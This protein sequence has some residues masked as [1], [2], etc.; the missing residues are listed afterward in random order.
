MEVRYFLRIQGVVQGVGFRPFVYNLARRFNLRGFVLNDSLGVIIEVEGKKHTVELFLKKLKKEAPPSSSIERIEK[1][2]IPL[3]KDSGFKIEESKKQEEKFVFIP[4]DLS[5]CDDCL[6][7][8]FNKDD[9]RYFY[10]FINCTKCGPRYTIIKDVPY[11]RAN[12]TMDKFKMCKDCFAEYSDA[13]SRRFH[14]QPNAC[15]LC[16][17]SID[18]VSSCKKLKRKVQK[19]NRTKTQEIIEKTA[20]ALYEGKIVAIKG[21]GGYHIACDARNINTVRLLRE[22]KKRATKPFAVMVDDLKVVSKLCYLKRKEKEILTS[23]QRPIV[24]LKI[25]KK[26]MWMQEVAPYQKFLGVMIA[27]TP[28]HYLLFYCLRKYTKDPILVMT[29]ANF[30]DIPIAKEE[31][32]V[33]RFKDFVYLFIIHNRKIFLRCD[34][35]VVW[36]F[37]NRKYLLRKARGYIPD[38]FPLATE[39]NILGCGAELKSTFSIAKDGWLVS[40]PYLGDLKEW[41]NYKFFLEVYD[42]FKKIFN[43]KPEIVAYD[44]H[45]NYLSTQFA[46]S[47]E[48]VKRI[49]VQHHHAHMASCMLENGLK[50]S[51]IGVIFDGIG[52]GLDRNIWGGE[53]FVGNFSRFLRVGYFD[54]FAL[55]GYEKAIKEPLRV[56]FYILYSIFGRNTS[57]A[58]DFFKD[59]PKATLKLLESLI[60]SKRFILTSSVGRLFDGLASLL[61]LKDVVSYE[62]EAAILVETIAEDFKEK[63]SPYPFFIKEGRTLRIDWKPFF[64]GIVKDIEN[65]TPSSYIAYRFHYTLA[66][67]VKEVCV[68][69]RKRYKLNKVVLSGGVFQNKLLLTLTEQL[70]RQKDFFVYTHSRFPCNDEGVSVGQVVIA[71]YKI[72]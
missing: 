52:F 4:Y 66:C 65:K 17:P 29:S 54:Y 21:I 19:S 51:V 2:R 11:D 70:L 35:S 57:L 67:I 50:E 48:G 32:E 37:K 64:A 71:S 26:E 24:L 3:K 44:L 56:A 49:P 15:F 41:L 16:G 40:S 43:F 6:D 30:K 46:L 60:K 58:I 23:P 34:D 20:Q 27:Y 33:F 13:T 42:H 68:K 45:P 22:K 28:L 62:A 69:I 36:I 55:L 10:P 1:R 72:N 53:F 5:I 47:I 14:A 18:L 63:V 61:R 8:L 25:K 9:R 39:A 12:T 38:F 31:K 59:I 7:E